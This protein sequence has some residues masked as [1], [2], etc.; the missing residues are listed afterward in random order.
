MLGSFVLKNKN[1]GVFFFLN[2]LLHTDFFLFQILE[3]F[4]FFFVKFIS[5]LND[6]V[7]IYWEKNRFFLVLK[8]TF[9]SLQPIFQKKKTKQETESVVMSVTLS[10]HVT[11]IIDTTFTMGQASSVVCSKGKKP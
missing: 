4:F 2:L 7:L 3:G 8:F 6:S 5:F 11:K 10:C 1:A 9:N